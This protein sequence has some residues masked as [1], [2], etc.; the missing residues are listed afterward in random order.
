ME[1]H[2]VL[3]PV[4]RAPAAVRSSDAAMVPVRTFQ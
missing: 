4:V 2:E 3:A 1:G